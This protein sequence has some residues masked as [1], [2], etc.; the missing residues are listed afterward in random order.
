M[1]ATLI[2]RSRESPIPQEAHFTHDLAATIMEDR[3]P[4]RHASAM[5]NH[6]AETTQIPGDRPFRAY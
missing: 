2:R 5:R 4:A 3:S 6:D 1:A